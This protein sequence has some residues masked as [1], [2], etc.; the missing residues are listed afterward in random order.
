MN[1]TSN[2]FF[3]EEENLMADSPKSKTKLAKDKKKLDDDVIQARVKQDQ[4]PNSK[5]SG[6]KNS[7]TS[8]GKVLPKKKAKG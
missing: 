2:P 6:L 3:H 1:Q 5:T 4:K 8:S 7:N